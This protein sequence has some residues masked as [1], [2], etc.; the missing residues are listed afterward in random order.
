MKSQDEGALPASIPASI[1]KNTG[2]EFRAEGGLVANLIEWSPEKL[3]ND[4]QD[5]VI[6][7]AA[8]KRCCDADPQV[9]LPEW[10]LTKYL[11]PAATAICVIA[12]ALDKSDPR[13]RLVRVLAALGFSSGRG[14]AGA[15]GRLAKLRASLDLAFSTV[16]KTA[17]DH[18]VTS[19]TAA[20]RIRQA[21]KFWKV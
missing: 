2:V 8:I 1:R 10:V 5:P 14:K 7:W 18:S 19:R 20:Q 3:W 15:Y 9:P 4:T 6:A 17:K 12:D 21:R 16:E 11:A 13:A